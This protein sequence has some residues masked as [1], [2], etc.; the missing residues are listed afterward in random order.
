MPD[1]VVASDDEDDLAMPDA[2]LSFLDEHCE[3]DVTFDK[4]LYAAGGDGDD[5]DDE[6]NFTPL[7]F[8]VAVTTA[9]SGGDGVDDGWVADAAN[10][11]RHN[12]FVV[13]RPPAPLMTSDECNQC[14]S[15]W[16]D[17]LHMLF[18]HAK[19]L[20]IHPKRD[21]LRYSEL[22]SR[23]KGGLRYDMRL[24]DEAA[25]VMPECW[26]RLTA[27]VEALVRPVLATTMTR[28]L[29]DKDAEADESG[30]IGRQ[31]P[32]VDSIGCV[33]SL[34]GSP[35]QHFHPD[36]TAEGLFNAFCPLVPV[37]ADNGPTELLPG[38]HVWAESALGGVSPKR[39][40][41]KVPPVAPLVHEPAGA[42][43]I[44]NYKCYHRGLGN[45]TMQPRPVAYVAFAARDVTDA[46]NF[47][48]DQSLVADASQ[49]GR[50]QQVA[51]S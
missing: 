13:L 8:D 16:V 40:E 29:A 51:V 41:G 27:A 21:I 39:G 2:L 11:L 9:S 18:E 24:R 48:A 43:L 32:R 25:G 3:G 23:T 37:L 47:P 36:G 31:Q 45:H 19:A 50:R 49:A 46:H 26:A 7:P 10:C 22:C 34:P 38:S 33:T 14:A 44:F 20:G 12:G 6:D 5:D 4:S 42:V 30:S 1:L 28:E 17:R 35:D 15:A